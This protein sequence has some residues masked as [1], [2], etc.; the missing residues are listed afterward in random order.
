[1]IKPASSASAETSRRRSRNRASDTVERTMLGSETGVMGMLRPSTARDMHFTI[2]VGQASLPV[3]CL[4]RD[5]SPLDRQRR[6]S[7]RL[8]RIVSIASLVLGWDAIALA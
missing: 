2:P 6:L 8:S 5:D 7:Q 4:A 3:Q 1:M